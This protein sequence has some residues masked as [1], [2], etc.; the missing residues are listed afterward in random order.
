MDEENNFV[1]RNRLTGAV[2]WLGTLVVIVPIWYNNPV[3]F[4]PEDEMSDEI[5]VESKVVDKPFTVKEPESMPKVGPVHKDNHD[6]ASAGNTSGSVPLK[7]KEQKVQNVVVQQSNWIIRV[8]AFKKQ[9]DAKALQQ[10]LKYDYEAF[11]KYFPESKYYS[12]RIGPY[13]DHDEAVKD[14]QRLNRV[15][16]IESELVRIK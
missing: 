1:L 11:T 8:A 14:Q 2:L 7:T 16:H 10:R 12:V 15:L 3:N 13:A 6:E 9:I 5:K 4:H